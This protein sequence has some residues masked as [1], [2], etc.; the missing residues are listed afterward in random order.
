M[1][2]WLFAGTDN[3][4]VYFNFKIRAKNKADA[5]AAGFARLRKTDA[6]RTSARWQC[7]IVFGG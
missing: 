6:Y 2:N 4:G 1:Y 3:N 7:T 5:I